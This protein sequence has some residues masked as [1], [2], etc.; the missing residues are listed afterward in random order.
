MSRIAQAFERRF[1]EL[2]G[3]LHAREREAGVRWLFER[4]SLRARSEGWTLS[5]ALTETNIILAGKLHRFRHR[6]GRASSF[7]GKPLI[8]DAGLGGLARWL[9]AAGQDT[10]WMPDVDD[11]H[12]VAE[13]ER[14]GSVIVTTDSMLLDRR[15]VTQGRVPAIWVPPSL[16]KLE[17]LRLVRAEL[18]C[19]EN[20]ESRCMRCGGELAEV[21]KETVRQRIPPRTYLWVN[22]YFECSRCHQ[23]FWHGTHWRSINGRLA[24]L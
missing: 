14:T 21:D 19:G 10:R 9:R 18:G 20:E 3:E 17:Q 8:C 22:E 7:G 2:L 1:R 12:L 16:R 13:A 6:A 24:S 15:P 11:G 4:A 23:L 5:K